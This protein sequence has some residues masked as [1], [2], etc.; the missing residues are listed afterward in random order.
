AERGHRVTLVARPD[1]AVP[2]RD[3]FTFYGVERLPTLDIRTIP[4][5]PGAGVRR[6]RFLVQAA[7]T[8]RAARRA[9]TVVMTRDL[10]LASLLV[11]RPAGPVRLVYESH[12]LS[13]VVAAE[14]PQLLGR[15]E[16]AP[17]PRKLARLAAREAHV[18]QQA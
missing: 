16:L 8:A 7:W 4:G 9:D 5:A 6:A 17:S 15:P 10:G 14:L 18:W 12:G 2:G 11:A 3:P 13:D 1:T